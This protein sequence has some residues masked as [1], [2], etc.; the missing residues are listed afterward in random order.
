MGPSA[1]HEFPIE[2]PHGDVLL[3]PTWVWRLAGAV[4]LLVALAKFLLWI[5]DVAGNILTW[6]DWIRE[7]FASSIFP[8][9][10]LLVVGVVALGGTF[11]PRLF[12]PAVRDF[13]KQFQSV[14]R[15]QPIARP[16]QTGATTVLS[17][18]GSFQNDEPSRPLEFSHDSYAQ[19]RA[20]I[21]ERKREGMKLRNVQKASCWRETTHAFLQRSMFSESVAAGF[22]SATAL[23][24]QSNG[25]IAMW[26]HQGG[27]G[28]PW[29]AG[30]SRGLGVLD[31]LEAT[32]RPEHV[33][34]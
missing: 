24:G 22:W 32:L 19:I 23:I 11:V 31:Q 14:A 6:T 5:A 7:M 33:R 9:Y 12:V 21:C 25:E 28:D 1:R 30:V 29:K 16:P 13:W 2:P 3:K 15:A 18:K 26:R 34:C 20:K 10:V 4:L 17:N 8:W 27:S